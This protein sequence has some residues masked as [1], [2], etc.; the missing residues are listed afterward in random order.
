MSAV[1]SCE[2]DMVSGCVEFVVGLR[3]GP[4]LSGALLSG[5]LP[6]IRHLFETVLLPHPYLLDL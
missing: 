2:G 6:I 4:F 3:G 1:E 5:A